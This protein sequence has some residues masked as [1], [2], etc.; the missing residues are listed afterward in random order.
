[1]VLFRGGW[2]P[3]RYTKGKP[4]GTAMFLTIPREQTRRIYGDVIS[5]SDDLAIALSILDVEQQ[6]F[7][8]QT[9]FDHFVVGHVGP[10]AG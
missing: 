3:E 6:K 10:R 1:M 9:M 8:V 5:G 4:L 2:L 7:N